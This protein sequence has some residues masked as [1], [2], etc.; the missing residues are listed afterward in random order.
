MIAAL[1][2]LYHAV[3]R[4]TG[5]LRIAEMPFKLR[6]AEAEA[7]ELILGGVSDSI[8][9]FRHASIK[10]FDGRKGTKNLIQTASGYPIF[11]A[12]I[13]FFEGAVEVNVHNLQTERYTN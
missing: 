9:F 12:D 10:A 11:L 7:K 3:I 1:G 5:H 2:K 6:D 8:R 4:V 13:S